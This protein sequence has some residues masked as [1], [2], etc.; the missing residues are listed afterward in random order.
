ML[1]EE[2]L[3]NLSDG[4][5]SGLRVDYVE[6]A[7]HEAFLRLHRKTS[8]EGEDVGI[9]MGDEVLRWGL[10]QDDV[11]Y[12]DGYKVIAVNIPPCEAI[13][14][15]VRQDHPRQIAKLCYEVGNTHTTMFCGEDEFTF[16]T[17]YYEPLMDK[18]NRIH[19]VSA[20][21]TEVKFDFSQALSSSINNHH[22]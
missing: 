14:M 13:R 8:A 19:G 16:Y 17:P 6:I 9:R 5:F 15:V 7:W 22:H 20:E 11:L 2:V 12:A 18:V 4:K 1:C 21:K 10:R 3:G